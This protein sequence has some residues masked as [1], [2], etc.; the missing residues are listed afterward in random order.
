MCTA[1]LCS[2]C[3]DS[4]ELFRHLLALS[5]LLCLTSLMLLLC[6]VACVCSYEIKRLQKSMDE[7]KTKS[8]KK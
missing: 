2:E 1:G 3:C 4:G 7:L 5:L 8:S 6:V